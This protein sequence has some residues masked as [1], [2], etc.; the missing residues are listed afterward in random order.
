MSDNPDPDETAVEGVRVYDA[1][2]ATVG[3]LDVR[4]ALPQ[5]TRRTIGPWCFADHLGPASFTE[6]EG[7]DVGPHPHVGLQTVTWLI[8][9]E[10][11]H[12]DSLGSEQVIKPGQLN[13]MTAGRGVAHAEEGTGRYRGTF[14]GIQLW[15]AQPDWS[16]GGASAFEHHH[17]LPRVAVGDAVV[18]VL[19]GDLLDSSSPAR[20]DSDLVGLD[21]DVHS[22]S[23]IPLAPSFE[24]GVIVL[25]GSVRIGEVVVAPGSLAHVPVGTAELRLEVLEPSRIMVI[26]GPVFEEPIVMWWNFVA[27][28]REEL[29]AA[30]QSWTTR[31]GRFAEVTS[32]LAPTAA[33]VPFWLRAGD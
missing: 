33:P 2:R 24:H 29:T 16:R 13:L 14:E 12:H 20:H 25:R 28:R 4:R 15:I 11:L 17:E 3:S 32:A 10:A 31:D 30:Y 1:H 5:R 27:R 18:T 26:G 23:T 21:V 6:R 19:L 22:T 9:G 7:L 8:D